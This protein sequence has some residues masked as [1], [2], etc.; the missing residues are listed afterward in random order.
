[1]IFHHDDNL[2]I[3]RLFLPF[4]RVIID[5]AGSNNL[6]PELFKFL[7]GNDRPYNSLI[8][9][10]TMSITVLATKHEELVK[11]NLEWNASLPFVVSDPF[12]AT[13]T[14]PSFYSTEFKQQD[15]FELVSS[16]VNSI[17]KWY[18]PPE[19]F[20]PD[21][22]FKSSKEGWPKLKRALIEACP[23]LGY[24]LVANG[25]NG[26]G[27]TK[28][29]YCSRHRP[30]R[31]TD[32]DFHAPGDYRT[33]HIRSNRRAG[34]RGA[35]G[36]QMSRRYD[37]HKAALP[38]GCC[39]V[40]LLVGVD[41]HGFFLSG[42]HGWRKHTF[43]PRHDLS[44]LPFAKLHEIPIEGQK[45]VDTL[46][47]A[48]LSYN[49]TIAAFSRTY[50]MMISPGQV[51]YLTQ[52]IT[53]RIQPAGSNTKQ[54]LETTSADRLLKDLCQQQHDHIILTHQTVGD[55]MAVHKNIGTTLEEDL[56]FTKFW[57]EPERSAMRAFISKQRQARAIPVDQD[58][59][60]AVLWVTKGERELFR[61]FPSVVKIDTTFGTN[62]RSMPLLSITGLNSNG[63]TFTI[64]R[65][66][67]P[68][69]QSWV[70]RWILSHALPHLLGVEA[71]KKIVVIIS[72]GDSTEI[73]QINNLVDVLCP[74][75]HRMRCGW[76]L[77]DRGWERLIYHIPKD[78]FRSSFRLFETTR[79]ILFSW[80][81]SWMTPACET[82]EE[83]NLSLQLFNRFLES[84]ELM[85]RVGPFFLEKIRR[86]HATVLSCEPNWVFHRRKS[87]FAREEYTNSSHEA[88]YRQV[89]Y[90]FAAVTPGMDVHQ[91][92]KSLS[93]Q[94]DESYKRMKS[95]ASKDQT[96]F[97]KWS[98][99]PLLTSRLTKRGAG[100]SEAQWNRRFDYLS[101]FEPVS[102]SFRLLAVDLDSKVEGDEKAKR[103]FWTSFAPRYRRVRTVRLLTCTDGLRRLQCSCYYPERVG[104]PCR[105]QLHVLATYFDDYITKLEDVHPFWWSS[106]M[107]NAYVRGQ[108]GGRTL[109]SKNLEQISNVYDNQPYTGPRAPIVAPNLVINQS[110]QKVFDELN[111]EDR[112]MNWTR[113]ELE[114]VLPNYGK[115]ACQGEGH[116]LVETSRP[117][118]GLSQQS[119]T[120]IQDDDSVEDEG[121]ATAW[122]NRFDEDEC[123]LS[124]SN[125]SFK[126]V[127]PYIVLNPI[128]KQLVAA[129]EKDHTNLKECEDE[130]LN[131]VASVEGK[132]ANLAK[133]EEGVLA[134]PT[135][136]RR[137]VNQK[138]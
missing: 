11:A 78:P 135:S 63:Q 29:L 81:Y 86:W 68:N 42:K 108:N 91:S 99:N 51:K 121:G 119:I 44:S 120:F 18:F 64:A 93:I 95:Q 114:T 138:R 35:A 6:F 24:S 113:E 10:P 98:T 90:G 22:D 17:L 116:V 59:F 103:S 70:F 75:V 1:M 94:A 89:K 100:L 88:S 38:S 115:T 105:H 80:S 67:L 123:R 15:L 28:F 12:L 61:K 83:Y 33:D 71:M 101:M 26:K 49:A 117:I 25:S 30:V 127:R 129:V 46:R 109:L 134:L 130:L 124:R 112:V 54:E 55:S 110:N 76:H 3:V 53:Y 5:L 56:A 66:Y 40:R 2:I 84:Q 126:N 19:Q 57:P 69:E 23:L 137:R 85:S 36:R 104:L 128:F 133:E 72:D 77:V 21:G 27:N 82:K 106:Y 32:A 74:Q 107:L 131:L 122:T 41:S 79:R 34:S 125:P 132:V 118:P 4:W 47:T 39:K 96:R 52:S 65:A 62:D 8:V 102:S 9:T 97:A 14:F 13:D 92:G 50:G 43:H 111:L 87:L 73:A 31:V 136:K 48:G 7:A 20:P 37:S 58:L 45:L 60:V 16:D